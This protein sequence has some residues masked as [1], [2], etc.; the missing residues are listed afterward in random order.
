ML[1]TSCAV[2]RHIR[3]CGLQDLNLSVD[4][5]DDSD[6]GEGVKDVTA[7]QENMETGENT[8]TTPKHAK[9]RLERSKL[10]IIMV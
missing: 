8:P 1:A 10:V 2:P 6:E 5:G 7:Q 4:E 3:L 9:A